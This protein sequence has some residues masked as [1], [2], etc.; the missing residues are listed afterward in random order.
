MKFSLFLFF[1][2]FGVNSY[3]ADP[4]AEASTSK[5]HKR[6]LSETQHQLMQRFNYHSSRILN[7]TEGRSKTW[8]SVAAE[9]QPATPTSSVVSDVDMDMIAFPRVIFSPE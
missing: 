1:Q 8:T 6:S 4:S 7:S 5:T 3:N 9:S 2:G